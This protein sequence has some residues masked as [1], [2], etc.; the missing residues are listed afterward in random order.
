[1]R[2]WQAGGLNTRVMDHIRQLVQEFQQTEPQQG[3]K[4]HVTG[5]AAASV[6]LHLLPSAQ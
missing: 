1:M 4:I 2:C 6:D 3:L 5:N